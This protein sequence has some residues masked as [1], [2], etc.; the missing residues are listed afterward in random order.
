MDSL[1]ATPALTRFDAVMQLAAAFGYLAVALAAWLRIPHD[2]RTL[3]FLAFALTNGLAFG[4][5]ADAWF[6]GITNPGDMPRIVVGIM[7]A[8][9]SVGSLLLFHFTQVFPARRPWIATA[10]V[11]MPVAYVLT[12]AIVA[13]LTFYAPPSFDQVTG[14]H[15]LA[16]LLFGFP[17]LILIGIVLP[18]AG[19]LSLLKSY[20][21]AEGRGFPRLK[22]PIALMLIGQIAGGVVAIVFA[23]V[24]AVL[25]TSSAAQAAL[26]AIIAL[27]GLMTPVAFGLAVWRYGLPELD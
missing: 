10:G 22:P 2:V 9:L 15:I 4:L 20:R 25:T 19:I 26:T 8:S 18:V 17:L 24:L 21:E 3:L 1:V 11:Q 7:I 27:V 14:W 13:G 16:V 6:R 5:L 23:P 12:P